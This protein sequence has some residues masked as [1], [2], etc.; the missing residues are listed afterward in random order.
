MR[1]GSS[2]MRIEKSFSPMICTWATP[3]IVDRRGLMT[4]FRY[5]VT[6]SGVM[7]GFCTA[8]YM[9]ANCWPVPLTMTGSF[10]SVGSLP[11]TWLT[12][13]MTSVS[14]ASGFEPSFMCTVTVLDDVALCDVT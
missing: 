7:F 1:V 11:R 5:S 10:A 3:S 12:F 4:R 2:Q 14:A 13:E 8:R 6:C 9:M